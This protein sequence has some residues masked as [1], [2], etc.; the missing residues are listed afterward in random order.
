MS[1]E[2]STGAPVHDRADVLVDLLG[3]ASGGS[4]AEMRKLGIRLRRLANHLEREIRRELAAQG[5]EVWELEV[6]LALRRAPGGTLGA[7]ALLRGSQVTAGAISNRLAR[8]EADGLVRRDADPADR[9]HTLVTLTPGGVRR[10]DCITAVRT[11]AEERLLGR[12][13]PGAVSRLSADLRDLLLAIEGPATD[14]HP[15]ERC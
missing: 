7:G 8:L 13:A 1:A 14:A 2:A 11:T 4:D 5:I 3:E 10:A 6:L 12:A 9:R 15:Y